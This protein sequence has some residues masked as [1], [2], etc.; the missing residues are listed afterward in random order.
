MSTSSPAVLC[1]PTYPYVLQPTT[2]GSKAFL[3]FNVDAS[4]T[5]CGCGGTT[6]QYT[7]TADDVGAPG[8]PVTIRPRTLSVSWQALLAQSQAVMLGNV[9]PSGAPAVFSATNAFLNQ[10]VFMGLSQ[11]GLGRLTW[12]LAP[13]GSTAVAATLGLSA[14][15]PPAETNPN[16]FQLVPIQNT[17]GKLFYGRDSAVTSASGQE[18]RAFTSTSSPGQLYLAWKPAGSIDGLPVRSV[19]LYTATGGPAGCAAAT[20]PL[21]NTF[22]S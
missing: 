16:Q 17:G 7:L 4:G 8:E 14:P 12:S 3:V 6:R 2:N 5:S 1:R 18:L 21:I 19:S 9:I 15:P 10:V 13:A 11:D 22:L 20:S